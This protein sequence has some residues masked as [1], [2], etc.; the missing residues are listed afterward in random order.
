M[1]KTIM[2]IGAGIL[3]AP[4]IKIAKEMGLK[5]SAAESPECLKCHVTG[6]GTAKNVDKSFNMSEGVTC[7]AC[8]GPA[9][10]YKTLHSKPENK[11]KAVEA[12][13]VLG[14]AKDQKPCLTCHN[15]E[16]PTYKKFTMAEMWKKIEHKLPAKEK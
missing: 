3:Q 1:Q 16:S 10:G 7:E 12:G 5:K 4:A 6:G 2:I 9:S 13:L 11:E 14:N 8:H 15:E